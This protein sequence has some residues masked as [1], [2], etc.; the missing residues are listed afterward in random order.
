VTLRLLVSCDGEW[1]GFPCRGALPL[2]PGDVQAARQAAI[3]AGWSLEDA[4]DLC[5]AHSLAQRRRGAS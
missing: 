4:R 2:P 3:T 5:P 1:H